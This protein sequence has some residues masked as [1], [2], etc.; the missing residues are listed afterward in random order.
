[1]RKAKL[2]FVSLALLLTFFL[3][4]R[5]GAVP[6][7]GRLVGWG[8]QNLIYARGLDSVNLD[9]ALAQDE[10]SYKVI[11]NIFEGLVRFQPGL[12]EVEPCLAE[13]W[14]VSPDGL[15]WTFF[16]RKNVR[17]Q[18]GTPFN[19]EAVRFSIE[20]QMSAPGP[21]HTSYASFVFGM[22]DKILTPDP[23]VV[24][25]QLKYP[26]TPF[27]HNLA[28]P[29]AAPMVSPAAATALGDDFGYRP[30]GTGPYSFVKWDKGN[31]IVLKANRDYWGKVP[32]VPTLTFSVI[33]N[34]RLRSMAL[35]L[36]LVDIID[37]I[38]PADARYLKEHGFPVFQIPGLDLNYLGFFTHQK[39]FDSPVTRRAFSMLIDREHL[40]KSLFPGGYAEAN[41]PLPPGVLGYDPAVSPLP[42]DPVRARE[43]LALSGYPN[44]TKITIVTYAGPRPYNP[45]GGEKMAGALKEELARAGIKAELKVYPWDRYKEALLNKEGDAFLYGWVSDN[46]DPDNFL[47]TLL[48]ST[49]IE[50]GLNVSRYRS[51]E[52]DQQLFKAQQEHDQ[53][54][55][56]QIYR[57]AVKTIVQDAPWVFLN[58]SLRL[59]AAAPGLEGFFPHPGGYSVL[60]YVKKN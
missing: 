7:A 14:R 28:M 38:N 22:V 40:I 30:V 19:A 21:D 2:L 51:R 46:G 6:V 60:N 52:V 48:S 50:N 23:F 33:K 3:I 25:F 17:F 44:G 5:S 42:Y 24:K 12:T 35:R 9:P 4:G 13:A 58:H 41:G 34:S 53:A 36:G 45:A 57:K 32:Q 11:Y 49:Q 26:Y 59:S 20:R 56:E 47:Y 15:E 18:D 37:E 10:E 39:P 43:L 29:A 1:M 55:R 8:E 27:L 31:R 54:L 16:L